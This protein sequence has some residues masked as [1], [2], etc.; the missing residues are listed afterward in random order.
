MKKIIYTPKR[1][2]H[3]GSTPPWATIPKTKIYSARLMTDYKSLIFLYNLYS[4]FVLS[5]G[6][7][8]KMES[9]MAEDDSKGIVSAVNGETSSDGNEAVKK[10]EDVCEVKN[11]AEN[12]EAEVE[13]GMH[14]KSPVA[15]ASMDK[16]E[17]SGVKVEN[18][19]SILNGSAGIQVGDF[20]KAMAVDNGCHVIDAKSSKCSSTN[21][22]VSNAT[23]SV[24]QD[25]QICGQSRIT[26]GRFSDETKDNNKAEGVPE[27]LDFIEQDHQVARF[28]EMARLNGIKV[29]ESTVCDTRE[30]SGDSDAEYTDSGC[31][32]NL[33]QSNFYPAVDI[34]PKIAKFQE[35]AWLNGI[36]VGMK[37]L[38]TPSISSVS[39]CDSS[40]DQSN[41]QVVE[42]WPTT[43]NPHC[44]DSFLEAAERNG[45]KVSKRNFSKCINNNC[46]L[47]TP[48][49]NVSV[50]ASSQTDLAVTVDCQ[51]QTQDSYNEI[52]GKS[53]GLQDGIAVSITKEAIEEEYLLWKFDDNVCSTTKLCYKDLYFCERRNREQLTARLRDERDGTTRTKGNNK[54]ITDELREELNLKS[55]ECEV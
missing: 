19:T 4:Y 11:I 17:M 7:N 49:A 50:E 32:V 28:Q 44:I 54:A 43:N 29:G 24:T 22:H 6:S 31:G 39:S 9:K 51:C 21:E 5:E 3:M 36:K 34:D 55:K 16:V 27:V 10:E 35:L 2:F 23:K 26:M 46:S 25:K 8:L 30:V 33:Q 42:K 53:E 45:I 12:F 18:S 38:R 15:Y 13:K 48:S 52:S 37:S 47:G 41:P 40:D 20:E 14:S 1:L